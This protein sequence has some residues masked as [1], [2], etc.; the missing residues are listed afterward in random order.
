MDVLLGNFSRHYRCGSWRN[1]VLEANPMAAKEV[2]G[3]KFL[4]R[5]QDQLKIG[6]AFL[7]SK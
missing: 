3:F 5:V 4:A 6:P 2:H 1:T 7:V